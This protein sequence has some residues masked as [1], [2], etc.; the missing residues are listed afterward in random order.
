[1]IQNLA[2]GKKVGSKSDSFR[3]FRIK[4]C[5]FPKNNPLRMKLS[6]TARNCQLCCFYAE[7]WCIKIEFSMLIFQRIL[8]FHKLFSFKIWCIVK[9]SSQFLTGAKK[10]NSKSD[11]LWN[12]WLQIW[13]VV[14]SWLDLWHVQICWFKIW[15]V[16]KKSI[17]NLK[18]FRNFG[19][20][21][22]S[23]PQFF[24]SH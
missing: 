3:R 17:E 15:H 14:K 4:I 18:L 10:V 12:F 6:K 19:S 16:F 23:F 8:I 24:F 21:N 7:R 22:V 9:F 5:F 11:T 20:K 13:W 1:M 2:G